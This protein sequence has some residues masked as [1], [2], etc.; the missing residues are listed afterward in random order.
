MEALARE[1]SGDGSREAG[2]GDW[3]GQEGHVG[4][5]GQEQPPLPPAEAGLPGAAGG[6]GCREETEGGGEAG[7]EKETPGP[8][9]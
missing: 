5:G 2:Q 7:G 3:G 4:T 9:L 8:G 1:R 6:E